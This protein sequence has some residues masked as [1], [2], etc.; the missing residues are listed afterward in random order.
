MAGVLLGGEVWEVGWWRD[1][2]VSGPVVE[3][4]SLDYCFATKHWVVRFLAG[5]PISFPIQ[6]VKIVNLGN[7]KRAG[8]TNRFSDLFDIF[9]VLCI[10]SN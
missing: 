1:C 5:L 2:L 4:S 9:S 10:F 3:I 8:M 7:K 6:I